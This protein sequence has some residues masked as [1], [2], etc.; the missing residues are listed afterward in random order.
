MQIKCSIC[1][2]I[3]EVRPG[4]DPATVQC[5]FCK[6]VFKSKNQKN[7]AATDE[8]IV[9]QCPHC[10]KQFRMYVAAIGRD[11]KCLNCGKEFTVQQCE[12][13]EQNDA[14]QILQEHQ[15]DSASEIINE[16]SERLEYRRK[17]WA[18]I[19]FSLVWLVLA[20]LAMCA[21]TADVIK[22]AKL[23][24]PKYG[25]CIQCGKQATRTSVF[26]ND[27]SFGRFG[28]YIRKDAYDN[29]EE[30]RLCYVCRM[31]M[32]TRG[33]MYSLRINGRDSGTLDMDLCRWCH[34][35]KKKTLQSRNQDFY[36]PEIEITK[37]KAYPFCDKCVDFEWLNGDMLSTIPHRFILP[38]VLLFSALF[39][40]V[41]GLA[42]NLKIHSFG[43]FVRVFVDVWKPL[44]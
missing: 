37:W 1:Q 11:I 23:I 15:A 14:P 31:R 32:M 21:L 24:N 35:P 3:I 40:G 38:V 4:A 25:V 30:K 34:P 16:Y 33:Q 26:G 17:Q 2:R 41:F 28:P 8:K 19:G 44:E 39:L 5:K 43:E 13:K 22:R 10:Q 6:Q 42:Y 7:G 9:T 20:G 12:A 36:G 27:E 29:C 18:L